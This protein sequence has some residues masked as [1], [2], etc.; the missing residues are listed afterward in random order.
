M[1]PTILA[2]TPSDI[3]AL[4]PLMKE[5]YAFDHLVFVEEKARATLHDMLNNASLGKIYFIRTHN[6]LAGYA[7]MVFIHSLEFHGKA[8]FLD[9]LYLRESAR[10]K[11]VGK[12]VLEFLFD[13]CRRLGIGTLR[14]E[15]THS[16]TVAQAVYEK[17]G[18]ETHD[19]NIMSKR[20]HGEKHVS[21]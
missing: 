12:R 11:G 14:L 10:G 13:E 15:V 1:P 5:Y 4:I 6:E 3:N 19:R 2:A 20:V 8:A 7:V 18:F 16:N 9:E 17:M 21:T